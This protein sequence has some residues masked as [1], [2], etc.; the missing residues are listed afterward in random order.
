[1]QAGGGLSLDMINNYLGSNWV[2]GSMSIVEAPKRLLLLAGFLL[3]SLGLAVIPFWRGL[4]RPWSIPVLMLIAAFGF[5]IWYYAT[6]ID[7]TTWVFLIWAI[8]FLVITAGLGLAKIGGKLTG[9]VLA[10]AL[11]LV[12]VNS[13][14]LN[15]NKLTQDN[16]QA[17]KY[18]AALMSLP[19]GSAVIV[20]HGGW[21]GLGFDYVFSQGKQLVPIFFQ[22]EGK[23]DN[24][25][26]YDSYAD[27]MAKTYGIMG[28]STREMAQSALAQGRS[29]YILSP[30]LF[31]WDTVFERKD[32]G[33]Y[34]FEQVTAVDVGAPLVTN[35]ARTEVKQWSILDELKRVFGRE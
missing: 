30:Q 25:V 16:P 27:W 29:V 20:H 2:V 35:D 10:G 26:I 13:V 32:V 28:E 15:A 31:G 17:M 12:L 9:V 4:K 8:P 22:F 5:S 6:S 34:R 18:Y 19:K 33:I 23:E 21:E 3:V 7:P 11:C 14:F 24:G 1:M